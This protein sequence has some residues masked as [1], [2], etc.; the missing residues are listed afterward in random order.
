MTQ[1][2]AQREGVIYT[3]NHL[4]WCHLLFLFFPPFLFVFGGNGFPFLP[5][6]KVLE[7][8]MSYQC[9]DLST[10]III[11]FISSIDESVE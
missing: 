6:A 9:I 1:R 7:L 2:L 5:F 3:E 4:H 11:V 10:I 8:N